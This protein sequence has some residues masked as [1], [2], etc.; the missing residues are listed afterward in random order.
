MKKQNV[1]TRK[2]PLP[3]SMMVPKKGLDDLIK[4]HQK[5][6]TRKRSGIDKFQDDRSHEVEM[7]LTE[8]RER[9]PLANEYLNKLFYMMEELVHLRGVIDGLG[10][11]IEVYNNRFGIKI[12]AEGTLNPD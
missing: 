9:L 2:K 7:Q 5:I 11:L 4:F 8:V 12:V 6:L 10:M 1:R 3:H